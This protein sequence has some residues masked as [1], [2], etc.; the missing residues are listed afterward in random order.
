MEDVQM[1][2]EY[3]IHSGDYGRHYAIIAAPRLETPEMEGSYVS[4]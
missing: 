1:G 3:Y 2:F 4:Q